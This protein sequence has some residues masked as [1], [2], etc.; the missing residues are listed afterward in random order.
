VYVGSEELTLV[1]C[2]M[3]IHMCTIYI[4]L[5]RLVER[6]LFKEARKLVCFIVKVDY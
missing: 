4:I 2:T 1:L 5:L 6:L 3:H